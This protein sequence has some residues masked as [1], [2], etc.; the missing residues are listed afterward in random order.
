MH[1][2]RGRQTYTEPQELLEKVTLGEGDGKQTYARAN[3]FATLLVEAAQ[4]ERHLN[5]YT[6]RRMSSCKIGVL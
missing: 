4:E 6:Q 3:T 5:I 2:E 1:S